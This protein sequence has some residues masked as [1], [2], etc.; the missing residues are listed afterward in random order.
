MALKVGDKFEKALETYE[1]TFDFGKYFLSGRRKFVGK[2]T[3][4]FM[5]YFDTLE[6][7]NNFVQNKL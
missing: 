6:E 4:R 3:E 7:L 5:K 2:T 1:V